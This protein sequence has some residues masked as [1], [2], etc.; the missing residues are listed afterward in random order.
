VDAGMAFVP[1]STFFPHGGHANTLRLSFVTATPEQIT[2]AVEAL[3]RVL[4]AA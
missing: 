4:A 1:G 3:G 2:T